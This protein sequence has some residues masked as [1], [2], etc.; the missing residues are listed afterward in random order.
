MVSCALSCD[1][2]VTSL[3]TTFAS[4]V[5]VPIG[6]AFVIVFALLKLLFE[7]IQLIK[8]RLRYFL[9]WVNYLEI[10]LFLFS[11]LFAFVFLTDCFCPFNWQ[12]ELGAIAVFL[13]WIDLVIIIR[14]LPVTGIYVVMFMNIFYIFL[15]LAFLA[16]LLIL[17][18]G[19]SFFMIFHNPLN[20]LTNVVSQ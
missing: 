18:F 17:A 6:A 4:L 2:H 3:D 15:K 13:S 5:F 1:C 12:W 20:L 10:I 19:F 7:L 14:K 8:Y 16:I 11:I 9:D